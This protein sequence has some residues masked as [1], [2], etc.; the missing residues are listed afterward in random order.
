MES[1]RPANAPELQCA[2]ASLVLTSSRLY[3]MAACFP[4]SPQKHAR[5]RP[6]NEQRGDIGARERLQSVRC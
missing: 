1:Y 4:H 2:A 3:A 6:N 5:L